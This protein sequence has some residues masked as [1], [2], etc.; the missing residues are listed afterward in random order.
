MADFGRGIKAGVVTGIVYM[1]IAAILGAIYY[2]VFSP[3]Q[4]LYTE[5]DSPYSHGGL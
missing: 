3:S 1:V 4:T 2:N 5:P